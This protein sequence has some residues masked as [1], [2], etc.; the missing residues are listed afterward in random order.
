MAHL[1]PNDNKG[2][3]TMEYVETSERIVSLNRKLDDLWEHL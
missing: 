3:D 2:D 1:G